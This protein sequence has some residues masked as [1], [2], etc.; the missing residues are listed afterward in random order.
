MKPILTLFVRV[1]FIFC[2][3]LGVAAILV[4]LAAL[5]LWSRFLL[6]FAGVFACGSIV[7]WIAAFVAAAIEED[8]D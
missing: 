7:L 2:A 6:F 1:S 5:L 4:L 8:I 3:L